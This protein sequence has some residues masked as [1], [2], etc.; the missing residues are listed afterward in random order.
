[1]LMEG[2][3]APLVGPLLRGLSAAPAAADAG[4]VNELAAKVSRLEATVER[5]QAA[6]E[7]QQG[8]INELLNR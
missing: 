4:H 2:L 6:M 1:M 8:I 3:V 5:Q 7:R